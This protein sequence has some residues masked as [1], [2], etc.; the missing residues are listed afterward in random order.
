[1]MRLTIQCV[2]WTVSLVLAGSSFIMGSRSNRGIDIRW[3]HEQ[4]GWNTEMRISARNRSP[5]LGI[6]P[7]SSALLIWVEYKL[8]LIFFI[9]WQ[10]VKD[11]YRK[12]NVSICFIK[13]ASATIWLQPRNDNLM[14]FVFLIRVNQSH[15]QIYDRKPKEMIEWVKIDN[16]QTIPRY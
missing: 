8:K 11:D 15:D 9:I 13:R 4:A 2:N 3:W 16:C 14:G 6:P 10:S 5:S 7:V 1:M 12:I